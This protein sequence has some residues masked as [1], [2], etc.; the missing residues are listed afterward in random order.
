MDGE[1]A[2]ARNETARRAVHFGMG[3]IA[4][5]LRYLTPTQAG[6]CA[7]LAVVFNLLVLPRLAGGAL[8]RAV[9][10]RAPWRSGVVI[11]PVAVLLLISLFRNR[12]EVAAA[13][14]GIMA[15]GDG[16]AGA[17]GRRFGHRALPWNRAKTLAG[18][19]AFCPAAGL[20]CWAL[21]VWMGRGQREAALLSVPTA[22][23]AAFVE[24]LPW[25][26]DDNLTVPLLSALFLRGLMEIDPTRLQATGPD[27]LRQFLVGV[28]VNLVLAGLFSR[29]GA[30]TRSGALAGFLVGMLT[31]TF[32]GWRGFAVLL[33]FFVLGS[34]AT[35][36]G[37]RRKQRLGVAQEKHGARSARHALA[38][39]GVAVYLAGL[40]ATAASP[41]IFI[42]A[43]VCAYATAAFD[44]VS[45]EV[46]QAF[47]GRPVL[48]TSLKTV[49]PGTN[50]A[51]SWL[52]TLAGAAA[53]LVVGEIASTSGLLPRDSLPLVVG[54]AFVGST[55]DSFLGATLEARGLMDND[56][57]NFSNTLAGALTGIGLVQ[58]LQMAW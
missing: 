52:G 1:R 23:F 41:E 36:L 35:R 32:S 17:F 24:S 43:F 12:L 46:G 21:L 40:I 5:T 31:F 45:S 47:G 44:T 34:A 48:I 7:A 13:A 39:C 42:L 10:R 11:Y 9:E 2:V 51:I 27:L 30:V 55:A 8:L 4:F 19:L 18:T 16:A 3:S 15:A 28:I 22:L 49:P 29:A 37:F 33:S 53:A 56:A 54:A 20:A 6:A 50:G 25:K 38:N 26:L 57:V 14:W 58:L